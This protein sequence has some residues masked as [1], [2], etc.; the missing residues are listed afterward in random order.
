[1]FDNAKNANVILT[2]LKNI[3]QHSKIFNYIEKNL[4]QQ[5]TKQYYFY[6]YSEKDK[7]SSF[8]SNA[9]GGGRHGKFL[10]QHL[11]T[12]SITQKKSW[13]NTYT[14]AHV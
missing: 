9:C 2:T 5:K 4:F 1:M 12:T 8:V 13:G 7:Y 10:V 3:L 6:C 11:T 14:L